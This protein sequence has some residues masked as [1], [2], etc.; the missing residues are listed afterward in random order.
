MEILVVRESVDQETLNALAHAWHYSLVK[1]VADISLGTVALGGEW[2]MD[3]NIKLIENGSEQ[4]NLWGFN[5][6]HKKKGAA[7]IEYMSLINIRPLQGNR[8]MEIASEE[9]RKAVRK[10]VALAIPFLKL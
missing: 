3:A 1:G 2:H 9:T 6:Y 7:A 5:I 4:K 10:I 8:T